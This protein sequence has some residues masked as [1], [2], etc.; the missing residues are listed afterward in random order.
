LQDVE[1][2]FSYS[3]KKAYFMTI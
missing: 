1:K 3:D 2:L